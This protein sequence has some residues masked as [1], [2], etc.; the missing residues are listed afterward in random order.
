[1]PASTQKALKRMAIRRHANSIGPGPIA[2][3]VLALFLSACGGSP[4]SPAAGTSLAGRAP[5]ALTSD[6]VRRVVAQAASEASAAG[7]RATIAVTDSEVNVLAVFRMD[8]APATTRVP[9]PS[10]N[11]LEGAVLPSDMAALAKAATGTLLSSGG[12]AFSTRTASF[13]V[14]DHFPP[15]VD[16]TPAGPLFGVQFSSLPCGDFKRP[17]APLGLSGDPGGLPLYKEGLVVGG[18]GVEGDGVYGVVA[19]PT[20][21]DSPPEERAALA[22][23]RGFDAPDLI[24]AEQILADGIRLPFANPAI[25]SGSSAAPGSYLVPP[26][27]GQPSAYV[28]ASAGGVSGRTDPRFPIRAGAVLTGAEVSTIIDQAARQTAVTRAAIRQP[29]GSNARVSIAVVDLDGKVLGFFQSEDAP[30]FGIDVAVQ[31]ARTANFF[32]SATAGDDLRHAGLAVYMRDGVPLD[33][34]VAFTSRAVGFLA[35]PHFPPGIPHTDPGAFSVP[36]ALWSPFNTGLQ[37]DLINL[38]L[39]GGCNATITRLPNGITVFPGGIPLFKGGRLAG[40]IGISGDGVDQDDLIS[41]AGSAG[42]E[43]PPE[44]RSDQLEIRGVRLPWVK[45]PRHPEL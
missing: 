27:D 40:A 33:G 11:G 23:A 41:S 26:R 22:G 38:G 3:C 24:R 19:D 34:S 43:A 16:F 17:A 13:I 25:L 18:V 28:A 12:N 30:N 20:N 6:E 36:S 9:G 10:G 29:L 2:P 45:F 7:L 35:Q 42:F 14:Q 4:G 44:R 31:K 8:G 21:L 32:S 37:L 5:P 1:V 15:G 39:S